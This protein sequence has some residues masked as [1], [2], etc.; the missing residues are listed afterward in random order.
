MYLTEY[1]GLQVFHAINILS[2]KISFSWVEPATKVNKDHTLCITLRT[3]TM[4]TATIDTH[5]RLEKERRGEL[6]LFEMVL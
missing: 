4:D 2:A 1:Y 6:I 3:S 5:R